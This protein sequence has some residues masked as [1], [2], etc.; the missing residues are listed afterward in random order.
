MMPRAGRDQQDCTGMDF[1]GKL[2]IGRSRS[3]AH[4]P[5]RR[6]SAQL[7]GAKMPGRASSGSGFLG[8]GRFGQRPVSCLTI[9]APHRPA[10]RLSG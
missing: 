8:V 9:T 2:R 3:L 4:T 6:R 5:A 10:L 1:S 7:G